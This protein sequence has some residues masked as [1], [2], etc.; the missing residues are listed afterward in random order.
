MKAWC[1]LI[2]VVV[3]SGAPF[4][5]AGSAKAQALGTPEHELAYVDGQTVTI[6]AIDLAQVAPS[7]PQRDFYLVVYPGSNP[8]G[9]QNYWQSLGISVLP[10]CNPCDHQGDGVDFID[11]H[12]HVLDAMPG[13][14]MGAFT[15]LW[16]VFVIIPVYSFGFAFAFGGVAF[17]SPSTLSPADASAA[18]QYATHLPLKSAV[19]VEALVSAHMALEVD[20]GFYFL[21]AVVT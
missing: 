11:F 7:T 3:L 1:V 2:C 17:P 10:Q 9:D 8:L 21:C 12:D 15:P 16:H 19:D 13:D 5:F 18:A 20:T 14:Q 6:N 4:V